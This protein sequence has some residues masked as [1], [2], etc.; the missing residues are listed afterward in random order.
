MQM[1]GLC[2]DPVVA[3]ACVDSA[4]AAHSHD[5]LWASISD[6]NHSPTHRCVEVQGSCQL[7]FCH[8]DISVTWS[9][10]ITYSK[11]LTSWKPSSRFQTSSHRQLGSW[12]AGYANRAASL[13]LYPIALPLSTMKESWETKSRATGKDS[14]NVKQQL[15][16]GKPGSMRE[17]PPSGLIMIRYC[18]H[19]RSIPKSSSKPMPMSCRPCKERC[20]LVSATDQKRLH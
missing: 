12:L 19:F 16:E 10:D 4:G 6:P 13:H 8:L 17:S 9:V 7:C 3:S 15:V 20:F 18:Y 5:S 11:R 1:L 2:L 14:S